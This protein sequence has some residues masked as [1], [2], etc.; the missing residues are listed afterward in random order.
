M[1]LLQFEIAGTLISFAEHDAALV[2]YGSQK[3]NRK[4]IEFQ[5]TRPPTAEES[6]MAADAYDRG[7]PA[8]YATPQLRKGKVQIIERSMNGVPVYAAIIQRISLGDADSVDVEILNADIEMGVHNIVTVFKGNVAEVVITDLEVMGIPIVLPDNEA[9][10]T[11][12]GSQEHEGQKITITYNNLPPPYT[13]TPLVQYTL[14]GHPLTPLVDMD[15]SVSLLRANEVT[16]KQNQ[17]STGGEITKREVKGRTIY[18]AVFPNI[19]LGSQPSLEIRFLNS[20]LQITQD[21]TVTV[22]RKQ[23]T[24]I[25]IRDDKLLS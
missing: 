25:T 10:L 14:P 6:L 16:Y 13:H 11:V 5:Y 23:I 15:A 24:E 1:A 9:V 2:I 3:H 7:Y 18:A 17:K 21:N 22:S 8:A 12:I 19:D 4:I 20:D